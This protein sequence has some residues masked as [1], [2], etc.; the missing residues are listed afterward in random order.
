MKERVTFV[1]QQGE[2]VDPQLLKIQKDG[3]SGP[4]VQTTREDKLTI[5]LDQ[6]PP[7]VLDVLKSLKDVHVRWVSP[8][9]YEAEE[10]FVS[11]VSPGLHISFTPAEGKAVET[12]VFTT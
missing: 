4:T 6:L 11:R 10:P 8:L 12:Y 7:Q 3:I 1:H 2:D 5:P 9:A